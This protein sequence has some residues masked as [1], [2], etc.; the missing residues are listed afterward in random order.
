MTSTALSHTAVERPESRS[1]MDRLL[2]PTS[3]AIVGIRDGS[4]FCDY[5]APTLESGIEVFFVNPRHP[6]V[7]SRDT[8]ASL[9]AI[10]RPIDAVLCVTNAAVTADIA[11]EAA[12]LDVGGLILVAGGFVESGDEGSALQK[13]V[14]DAATRGGMSVVG[15]NGLGYINVPR[16]ISLTMASDH[17]RRPGGISVASQS[18]ALLSGIA[19]AAWERASIGLH[20]LLSIGNEAV[21]DVADFVDYMVDDPE[22]TAIGLVI[23]KIRRPEA[24][25]SAARRALDAG[26]PIVVLKLARSERT[27]QMAASHTGSLTGDSWVYDVALAQAGITVAH[28][29]EELIDRLAVL[30]QLRPD[31]WSKVE[32]LAVLTFTGG[33]ASM[34]ADIAG[35]EGVP[36]PELEDLRPWVV[37]N[38][39]GVTV[40]N[41]LDATGLGSG[42][43]DEILQVY[44]ESDEIDAF[45]FVHPMSEEDERVGIR[46]LEAFGRRADEVGKPFVATSCAGAIGSWGRQAIETT[47]MAAARGPRAAVRGLESMGAF[48]RRKERAVVAESLSEAWIPRPEAQTLRE[49]EGEMLPFDQT[50]RLLKEAGIPVAEYFLI[51]DEESVTTPPFAGPYV[52]KLADVGHRTEHGAVE[53]GIPADGL[54]SAVS[55]MREIARRDSLQPRVA[56]QPMVEPR[57]E[58]FI[59][60]Q[61]SEL[62][63]MVI[64]GL[65]GIFV[66]V[67]GRVGGRMAPFDRHEAVE[68]IAEFS[69]VKVMHGF[70]GREAWD[71]DALAD[72]LVAAGQ[73]ADR[74]RDWL[75]SFDINPLIYTDQGFL[76][77]DGLCIIKD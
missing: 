59:G 73:F 30:Q 18:G 28:D 15:P 56:V 4:Q 71:L 37:E 32:N 7:M 70:R 33:F 62:G 22:T 58:A 66:E 61:S 6:Q 75:E 11:E 29:P 41:P 47:N 74:S 34:A 3:I 48:V 52:V 69:D 64:F 49:P 14:L 16:R 72:V 65:G 51:G 5:I 31:T 76:A 55:R 45:L 50:M 17:R 38:L 20:M 12:D 54:D 39:P 1:S 42:K 36:V 67:L 9:T 60:I 8:V 44:G 53:L 23:E 63:P 10:G 68:L 24:F 25:F 43:W 26:K 46:F 57:G 13:R 27:Q 21:N 77:V 40:P 35:D 19:M 2:K